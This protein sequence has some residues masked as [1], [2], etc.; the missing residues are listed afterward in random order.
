[1]AVRFSATCR[2]LTKQTKL[3]TNPAHLQ[4]VHFVTSKFKDMHIN[5]GVQ[6]SP[7]SYTDEILIW[8]TEE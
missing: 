2:M 3:Y 4:N 5:A 6:V 1:M 7:G 8:R